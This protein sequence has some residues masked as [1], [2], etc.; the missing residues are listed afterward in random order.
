MKTR[1]KHLLLLF[2][3]SWNPLARV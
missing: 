2:Q 3:F 1:R